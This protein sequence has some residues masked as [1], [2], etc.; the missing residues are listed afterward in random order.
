[1][2]VLEAFPGPHTAAI[3]QVEHLSRFVAWWVGL[4]ILS[5]VGL[6]CGVH[7]G[8]LF[9]FPHIMKTCMAAEEC[10]TLDF[11]SASDMWFGGSDNL[12]S[13]PE[14]HG[15]S[16]AL[17]G[18]GDGDILSPVTYL[19]TF[20]KVYPA[21]LLWGIGT[22]IG[23]IPPY[24][25]SRAAAEANEEVDDDA[26]LR[27]LGRRDPNAIQKFD[28]VTRSKMWMIGLL[29]RRGFLGVFLLSAVPNMA[30][31][32][33]GMCCGHF[34][35]PFR[36]FFSAILLGKAGVK[37]LFQTAFFSMLFNEEHL[38]SFIS[39]TTRWTPEPWDVGG[40]V[41]SAL[42]QVK[43]QF[44]NPGGASEGGEMWSE[45]SPMTEAMHGFPGADGVRGDAMPVLM[46]R[47]K[48]GCKAVPLVLV[49]VFVCSCVE[50]IAK[51][52]AASED[53]ER[54]RKF[55]EKQNAEP[56]LARANS[57]IEVNG[58]GAARCLR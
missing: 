10:N 35:M 9:L 33:C 3:D 37:V 23:E 51:R 12:F 41:Q 58:A 26:E 16:E 44:R 27:E 34:L 15:G 8:I 40:L 52:S 14:K 55:V 2:V 13:C 5:S 42:V 20:L 25:L 45:G 30:F 32:L 7:S 24:A 28:L 39:L 46:S 18:E 57:G 49:L 56:S 29:R 21:S 36:T 1:M 11:D 19:G 6:G 48:A 17:F 50:E 47:L 38:G 31:D 4:G 53:K 22:A 54:I 43:A